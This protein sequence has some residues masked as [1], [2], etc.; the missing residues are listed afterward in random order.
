MADLGSLTASAGVAGGSSQAGESNFNSAPADALETIAGADD[1]D[2][3]Y[4]NQNASG[5]Y[6]TY[7]ELEN[8]PSDFGSIL[9]LFARI[10]YG[11][12]VAPGNSAWNN[13]YCRLETS[14][15]VILAAADA[16][17]TYVTV[18]S[19]ITDTSPV[20]SANVS[21]SY[22]NTGATKAQ[23]D[24]AWYRFAVVRTKTKGGSTAQQR[25]YAA[26][27]NG[28]YDVYVPPDTKYYFIT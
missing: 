15:G 18:A 7:Y 5:T 14:A 8:M 6:G 27:V 16:G 28:T 20:N 24:D 10:R 21:F 12:D 17:G 2:Y 11:W 13:L 4:V 22:V 25:I 19:S 26:E 9:T 23:W 3:A 1:G